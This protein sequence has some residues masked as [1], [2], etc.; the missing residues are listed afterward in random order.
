VL[1]RVG[2]EVQEVPRQLRLGL[3]LAAQYPEGR[4]AREG[5]AELVEQV[6]LARELG[7]ASVMAGQ[8]FLSAPYQMAQPVPLLSRVA[9]EA[10]GM[11][12]GP[13]VQLI[14]LLNPLQVAEEMATLDAISGGRAVLGVGIGYRDV[15]FAGFGVTGKPSA[16]FEGK[17]DVVKRL[18]AGEAV[19]AS[20]PGYALD[21]A[22]LALRPSRRVPVWVA[23]NR[24][25]AVRRA[26][27]VGDAWFMNPHTTLDEL[28]R[29]HRVF[30][31]EREDAGLP[32][33]TE[34]PA[35]REVCV[36]PTD[37]EAMFVA[38]RF[39]QGKYAAYVDW[40][41][42]DVMPDGDTLRRAWEELTAGGR[43]IIGSP[44]TAGRMLAEHAERAGTTHL[45]C[46]MQ[47]P[48]MEQELVL[49]SIRL[50]VEEALPA[51]GLSLDRPG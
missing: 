16:A 46:R 17:L 21:G 49:R 48:G 28:E 43:F 41:Q 6:A 34:V 10:E 51:S 1:V 44:E 15:E 37:E 30:V 11:T 18:L 5:I 8:H 45:V 22:R 9:A 36:A 12:L 2:Q 47:W 20:G 42:S 13:G 32:V 35:M 38:G 31:G 14:P 33:P 26:A 7:F 23:A 4:D 3:F 25:V 39:L 29:Q 27:R 19:T 24:D 40:G 50:L